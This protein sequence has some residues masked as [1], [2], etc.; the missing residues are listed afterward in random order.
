VNNGTC[1]A[2]DTITVLMIDPKTVKLSPDT[3]ACKGDTITLSSSVPQA[4]HAWSTGDTT[5]SIRVTE[6]G[7]VIGLTI[8]GSCMVTDTINVTFIDP[9]QVELGP[10]R[11]ICEGDTAEL[12]AANA[13]AKYLWSTGEKTQKIKIYQGGTYWVHVTGGDCSSGDTVKIIHCKSNLVMPNAFTPNRDNINDRF[14]VFGTDIAKGT[15]TITNRW[16]QKVWQSEDIFTGWDGT[17]K[18][19]K[20]PDGVYLWSLQYW[21]FDGEVLY[22]LHKRGMMTLLRQ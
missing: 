20:C 17:F 4:R 6:S 3:L 13:G 2:A 5:G 22:P 16:G 11:M 9:P 12:D 10:A 14:R 15:L 18:G 7:M 19:Q 21:E 1:T 8:I